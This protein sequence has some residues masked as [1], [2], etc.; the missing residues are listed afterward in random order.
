MHACHYHCHCYNRFWGLLSE[1]DK[2]GITHPAEKVVRHYVWQMPFAVSSGHQRFLTND[3][4]GISDVTTI[5]RQRFTNE[6]ACVILPRDVI[7]EK[8]FE[9]LHDDM[10]QG[11]VCTLYNCI[12]NHYSR[13]D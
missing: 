9:L 8:F 1:C 13:D 2:H 12:V 11:N 6:R 5:P 4:P 7:P 3:Y 10:V